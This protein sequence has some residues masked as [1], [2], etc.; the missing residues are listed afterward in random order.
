MVSTILCPHCK[1][2]IE[3]SEALT[4]QIREEEKK[5]LDEEYRKKIEDAKSEGLNLAKKELEEKYKL[6]ETDLKKQLEEKNIKINEF[7][8]QELKLREDKRMLEEREKELKLEVQRQIDEEKK[9]IEEA[10]LKQAVEEHKLKD[11]EKE[12][13]INDLKKS[14]EEANRKAQQGSQQLQ[15]EVQEIDLEQT[16]RL[17]FP[18]DAIEP[19]EKG[20]R[21]ADIRQIVKT[22]LGNI[23]GVILWESK[24]TK[25]WSDGWVTKL[26]DDLR[27]EKANVPVIIS[28]VLPKEAE[29]GMGLKEGVWVCS[30]I[31]ALPL[32]EMLRQ[33][34]IEVAKERFL[35]QGKGEKADKLYSY[36]T[37][38]EFSQ[39]VEAML[40]VYN[41]INGQILKERAAFERIWKSRE[42]Q[43]KRLTL[44]TARVVGG[45]MGQVGSSSMPQ[46][47]GLE[48]LEVESGK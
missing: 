21:G 30:Y 7:R 4:H 48:L 20:V 41:D 18:T 34:L 1:K 15:G 35:A 9:K 37:S 36:I 32:A 28:T 39:Q 12:K 13:I 17:A 43:V 14:L 11:L 8:E 6:E 22:A 23:C 3:I 40:E 38:H 5:S 25:A 33:R 16:L 45:I 24:R 47:K 31:L 44:S 26:K 46:I 42:E 19:V 29:A 2:T 10:V 27:A